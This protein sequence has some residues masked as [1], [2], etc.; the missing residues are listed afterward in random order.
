MF[1]CLA[2]PGIA[3]P[4]DRRLLS[5]IA[6]W[7]RGVRQRQVLLD[8]AQGWTLEEL[9]EELGITSARVSQLRTRARR[10]VTEIFMEV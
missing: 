8:M 3:A 6:A 10:E 4:E 1:I 5:E 7:A 2:D 9:G